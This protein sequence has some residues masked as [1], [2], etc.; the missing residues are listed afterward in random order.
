VLGALV[1]AKLVMLTSVAALAVTSYSKTLS[2]SLK[3]GEGV[4]L[5]SLTGCWKGKEAEDALSILDSFQKMPELVQ[6]EQPKHPTQDVNWNVHD[7]H[8][9]K[10]PKTT[11]QPL[12]WTVQTTLST[13]WPAKNSFLFLYRIETDPNTDERPLLYAQLF[14]KRW[15]QRYNSSALPTSTKPSY[16]LFPRHLNLTGDVKESTLRQPSLIITSSGSPALVF[17]T[18]G[19]KDIGYRHWYHVIEEDPTKEKTVE[20]LLNEDGKAYRKEWKSPLVPFQ[21]QPLAN[22]LILSLLAHPILFVCQLDS[23]SCEL[24]KQEGT[25]PA[26]REPS[27]LSFKLQATFRESTP[28]LRYG[29]THYYVSVA[30]SHFYCSACAQ[31]Q[32]TRPHIV[33]ATLPPSSTHFRIVY[34]SGPLNLNHVGLVP[35][36]GNISHTNDINL[37]QNAPAVKVTSLIRWMLQEPGQV[38][39]DSLGLTLSVPQQSNVVLQVS[40]M[41]D[42]MQNV[43][44][45]YERQ[46]LFPYFPSSAKL[47]ECALNKAE[48]QLCP[49]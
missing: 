12:P 40:G 36:F 1:V 39:G 5:D 23:A 2:V 25:T 42:L 9:P 34:T 26:V 24:M 27:S 19:G 8:N 46:I 28:W 30:N 22:R 15:K 14:N 16:L 35:P 47:L 45:Q 37:C 31:V 20:L 3:A 41:Q 6:L 13:W 32:L 7:N 33:I 18:K 38:H 11:Y 49:A 48:H 21:H 17:S 43:I 4:T 10:K 29:M 44:E